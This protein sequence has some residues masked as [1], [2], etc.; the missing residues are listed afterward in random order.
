MQ[1]SYKIIILLAVIIISGVLI[2]AVQ[3]DP[4]ISTGSK[5][6]V[7]SKSTSSTYNIKA[8]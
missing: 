5:K 3:Q 2:N 6:S 7:E 8:I 4:E 1:K